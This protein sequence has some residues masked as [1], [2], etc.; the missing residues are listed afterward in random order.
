[1]KGKF[2]DIDR[3]F[4][5]S[6]DFLGAL[7]YGPNEYKIDKAYIIFLIRLEIIQKSLLR[8]QN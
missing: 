7:F 6:D 5:S 8:R 4:N 2:S 3:V 1:M